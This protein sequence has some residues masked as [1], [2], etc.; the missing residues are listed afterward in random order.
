[1]QTNGK[2]LLTVRYGAGAI[3]FQKGKNAIEVESM[4][5]L[6]TTLRSV[7]EAVADGELD[8]LL[9]KHAEYGSRVKEK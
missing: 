4:E 3:E 8:E 5:A 2:V 7:R 6:P 1:V 9:A